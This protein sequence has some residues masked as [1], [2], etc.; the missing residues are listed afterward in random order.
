[1]FS[2]EG[3]T[4]PSDFPEGGLGYTANNNGKIIASRVY[5]RTWDPP[6]DED[7][8]PWPGPGATSHGV[9][10]AGIMAGNEVIA[11]YLS[12][13]ETISGVAPGAWLM[14][15]RV[16]YNSVSGDGSFYTAEGI[17]ALEDIAADGADVL[18]NSWG[19]GPTSLGG[20]FDA[21]DTAL[22]NVAN[23]GVFVTMSAGNA[24]PG[25]GTGDHPSPFYI[26]VAATTTTATLTAGSLDVTAPEPIT[27]TLQNIPFTLSGE[28]PPVGSVVTLPFVVGGVIS[29]TNTLGCDAWT[30]SD[31]TGMALVVSRGVCD[32]NDKALNAQE[33]GAEMII[34]HNDE[35]RGDDLVSMAIGPEVNIPAFFI[36]YSRGAAMTDWYETNGED[37]EVTFN[38]NV[39]QQ[40]GNDPDIV[41]FFSSRGPG[42]G[43]V[44]KPDIA[45]PGVNI[46]SQGFD[47]VAT[48]VDEHLGFGQ[49][50]GTSMAAPHVSGAAALLR[51][52]HPDWTN[53]Q[54]KSALMS[55][56][57]YIG[58]YTDDGEH[59]QPLDMGAGRLDLARAADPGLVLDPPNIGFGLL[60]VGMTETIT[61]TV[62]S[63]S[64]PT[65]TY[66]LSTVMITATNFTTPSITTHPSF[67]VSPDSITLGAN[68]STTISITMSA[69]PGLVGDYQGYL[70][71][72]GS[73]H[74]AHFPLWGRAMPEPSADVLVIDADL[75][76]QLAMTDY[77]GY[78]TETLETLGLTYDVFDATAA[79]GGQDPILPHAAVLASYQVIVLFT[80]DNFFPSGTF[81]VPTPI[82][83]LDMD[84]LTEYANTGGILIA[85]GQDL[86]AVANSDETDG[87][88][89]FYSF[90]LGGNWLQDS[91][92][93]DPPPVPAELPDLP[94]V[95]LADAPPAFED[96]ALD[97]SDAGDG[98]GNQFFVDEIARLPSDDPE[99]NVDEK[100]YKAL[101]RYPGSGMVEDG[102]VGIAH[103]DQPT[104]E[105]PG[106][107]YLGRSIYTTFGLEG[108]N[109]I[110]DH[111][112]RADLLGTFLNWGMDEP[113]VTI[114][115]TTTYNTA[116]L[117][118]F[119][120]N[121]TSEISGTT[122]VMYR[123]DFGDGSDFTNFFESN[124]A[125]HWY[126]ECGDYTVRVEA[127]DSYG[128]HAVA[129]LE[130]EVTLCGEAILGYP[131]I[132]PMIVVNTSASG[133]P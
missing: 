11:D 22:I 38:F 36:G 63:V 48:G 15:Y 1:M 53:D 112:S 81:P 61:V 64:T 56:S 14:S 62:S 72:D 133:N 113:S 127:V 40:V 132:L 50:S 54:I 51:Q 84:R 111:T 106:V 101:L 80:G 119:E 91:I 115:D 69:M 6:I 104:L 78:Y 17:A 29:P 83:E 125:G 21:L 28:V 126:E 96:L 24:G 32:F 8:N 86:S 9:H 2:G 88:S 89:F 90:L 23:S 3:F 67:S 100:V 94:V 65:E 107:S 31:F 128:N 58:V 20:V 37:S 73:T 108:V 116:N 26:N 129:T 68:V 13:T 77:Q 52:V 66:D 70:V 12:I 79:V 110:P 92:S 39:A 49:V 109:D 19:G 95:G 114:S 7:A 5:F 55:T 75:S 122:G 105:N 97:L 16:F 10:T 121:L 98:A 85:M 46:L 71:M 44:A 47:P 76:P 131:V 25:A 42:V 59:A 82:T 35:A 102:I 41:A 57:K 74:E 99:N 27:P 118:T 34:V 30:G 124:V 4:Y 93:S 120:V 130:T 60:T 117:T 43:H 33:A 18:N 103:R 123:W 87:G 45:A